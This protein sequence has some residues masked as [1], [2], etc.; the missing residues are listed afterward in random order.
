[1]PTNKASKL[2][3]HLFWL[4]KQPSDDLS[5]PKLAIPYHNHPRCALY[6]GI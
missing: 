3:P 2:S 6:L 5:D 1:M 4:Q